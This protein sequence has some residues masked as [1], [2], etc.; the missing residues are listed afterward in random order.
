M[1]LACGTK[2]GPYEILAPL[3]AGGMA[4][5]YR[6]HDTR[7]GRTVAI[8]VLSAEFSFHPERRKRL[9]REARTLSS[10]SHPHICPLFDIG[11]QDGIDFLVMEYLE[12]ETL[13]CKLLRGPLPA[14]QL[15]GYGIQIAD[16]IETAHRHGIIHRDLKPGNIMLTKQ[17]AKL[18]DFGLARMEQR[19]APASETLSRLPNDDK[20][21]EEGAILGTFQYMAP[22]QLEGKD[23][24]A[25]TDIFAF[26]AVLYEMAT[27]IVAFAGTTRASLIA[28]ILTSEPPSINSLQSLTPPMLERVVKTC[29]AKD[30][31]ARWQSAQ[32]LKLQLQWI[33]EGGSQAGVPAPLAKRRRV[34][35][36][37]ALVTCW[38]VGSCSGYSCTGILEARSPAAPA[39]Q[40]RYQ[41]SAGAIVQLSDALC[42]F[43]R[44]SP[45]G[46]HPE[47]WKN[48]GSTS[49]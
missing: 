2:L 5:V 43:S 12:G 44:R 18:L 1:A 6:A 39:S 40:S 45:I 8:K 28:A 34:R 41:C 16:A 38:N 19:A 26:G 22:E 21:T 14:E 47:R 11:H 46:I 25:R 4:E 10:L 42:R 13:A 3:G 31:D 23:A 29:L 30:P 33:R 35:E 37:V 15:L 17:G 20:L 36:R 49:G 9:E 32:D 48:L 24:D 7:L 27:G